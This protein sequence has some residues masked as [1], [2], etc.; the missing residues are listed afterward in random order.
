M[1]KRRTILSAI[2]GAFSAPGTAMELSETAA[3]R[4]LFIQQDNVVSFPPTG[5]GVRVGT[6]TGRI[7]GTTIENFQFLPVPPPRFEANDLLVVTDVDGDQLLFL[8]NIAGHF[9]PTS[10][11][12][13]IGN[14]PSGTGQ[15]NIFGLGGPF[16]GTYQVT[17]ATGKYVLL[18]NRKFP[19]RG[20]A[21][22]PAKGNFLGTVYVEVFSDENPR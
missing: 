14:F 6:A 4:L 3:H 12:G 20:V 22:N 2:L 9:L 15:G 16:T 13:G 19:C 21:S 7:N 1:H 18:I 11:A 5:D 17:G 8:V 10:S